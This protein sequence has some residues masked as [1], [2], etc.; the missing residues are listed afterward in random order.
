MPS[1]PFDVGDAVELLEFL[2][3]ILAGLHVRAGRREPAEALA[4]RSHPRRDH[5][6]GRL[7]RAP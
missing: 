3:V 7:R 4:R 1:L 5:R 6:A 2:S